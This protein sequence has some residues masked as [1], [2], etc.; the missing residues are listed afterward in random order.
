MQASGS[1]KTIQGWKIRSN[2]IS[3]SFT[4]FKQLCPLSETTRHMLSTIYKIPQSFTAQ[5]SLFFTCGVGSGLYFT[6]KSSIF[7]YSQEK[8]T[9]YIP[10]C[11]ET[12]SLFIS[13]DYL[14]RSPR[15]ADGVVTLEELTY[16]PG[17]IIVR[18]SHYGRWSLT[19]IM[20]SMTSTSLIPPKLHFFPFYVFLYIN[21]KS[22]KRPLCR[23]RPKS[24][25]HMLPPATG[26]CTRSLVYSAMMTGCYFSVPSPH[27]HL[28]LFICFVIIA[29]L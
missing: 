14:H 18:L 27:P 20:I 24:K 1:R 6:H 11:T 29:P 7:C 16:T 13:I 17:G 2:Y 22:N 12:W 10:G 15:H 21:K 8:S 9:R 3:Y 19:F 5:S 28:T 26:M 4:D 23:R 25:E